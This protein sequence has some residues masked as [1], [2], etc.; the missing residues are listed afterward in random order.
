MS[1]E[2]QDPY[3]DYL[4]S[5]FGPTTATGFSR[6]LEGEISHDQVTRFLASKAKTSADLWRLAKPLV[7][8]VESDDGALAVDD[9][10]VE[11]PYT[12]ENGRESSVSQQCMRR[13]TTEGSRIMISVMAN[14]TSGTSPKTI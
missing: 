14:S 6:L 13:L 7:R 10:I 4:I 12:D 11:K 1:K 2:L 5:S 3:T 9:S 8:Q